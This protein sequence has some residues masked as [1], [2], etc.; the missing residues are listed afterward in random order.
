MPVTVGL[1]LG[2][3]P[4]LLA[5]WSRSW[6]VGAASA[7]VASAVLAAAMAIVAAIFGLA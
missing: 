5:A 6:R 4:T 3:V 2:V 7:L 1:L